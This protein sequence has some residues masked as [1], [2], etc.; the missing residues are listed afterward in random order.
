MLVPFSLAGTGNPSIRLR[1]MKWRVGDFLRRRILM[2]REQRWIWR[3]RRLSFVGW[4]HDLIVTLRGG[5]WLQSGGNL[6]V[7]SLW[8]SSVQ[9]FGV[10][11]PL[12][13]QLGVRLG[14]RC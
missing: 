7:Q 6:T 13:L 14:R 4:E 3:S 5:V 9:L 10:D 2:I 1:M 12:R 11:A 8:T